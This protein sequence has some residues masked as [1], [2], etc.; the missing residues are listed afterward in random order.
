MSRKGGVIIFKR[1]WHFY[2]PGKGSIEVSK[3]ATV[4]ITTIAAPQ[5][6]RAMGPKMKN[7]TRVGTASITITAIK[8][9]PKRDLKL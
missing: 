6:R 3:A 1:A 7:N 9:T 8:K 2:F 5:N 4:A